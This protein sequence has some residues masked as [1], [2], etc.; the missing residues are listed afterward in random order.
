MI[1]FK[2]ISYFRGRLQDLIDYKRGV[3]AGAKMKW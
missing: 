2:T 1:S 3:Y